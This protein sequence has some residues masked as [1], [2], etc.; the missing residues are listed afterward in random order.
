LGVIAVI[1]VGVG[2]AVSRDHGQAALDPDLVVVAPFTVLDPGLA[3]WREGMVDVLSRTLDGAG[4]LRT[5]APSVVVQRSQGRGD[6]ASAEALAHATRAGLV[7]YGSL[8]TS[9]RDSARALVTLLNAAT[10]RRL[11]E[12]DRRES[13]ERLDHL[14]DTVAVTLLSELNRIRPI[15]A[16]RVGSL[17]ARSLPALR[18]FLRGEQFFRRGAYDSAATHYDR[19]IRADS[20]FALALR[21]AGDALAWSSNPNDTLISAYSLRAGA[22]NHGLSPRDSLITLAESLSAVLH[23]TFD[24]PWMARAH[25]L[26]D[27][28]RVVT[29]RYPDDPEG[30][31]LLGEGWYHFPHAVPDDVTDGTALAAFDRAIALDSAFAP[32][33]EHPVEL[34][35]ALGGVERALAYARPFARHTANSGR[36]DLV[37]AAL[38]RPVDGLSHARL[39]AASNLSLDAAHLAFRRWPD[40]AETGLRIMR[41]LAAGRAGHFT[42]G[43]DS[44]TAA[45]LLRRA[46]TYRGRVRE[47]CSSLAGAQLHR[48]ELRTLVL[49]GELGVVPAES[50]STLFRQVLAAER[51]GVG[52]LPGGLVWWLG[53]RDRAALLR[54]RQVLSSVADS[55][56]SPGLRHVG[57]WLAA[58]AQAFTALVV[59]D[60]AAALAQLAAIAE[61]YCG[62]C[63]RT[64]HVRAEVLAAT[65]DY[66]GAL[67]L[68]RHRRSVDGGPEG[69]ET[70]LAAALEGR[71][72]ERGGRGQA[73]R[74]AY[75]FVVAA[76]S[77]GDPEVQAHV[78]GAQDAL[79]RLSP[80][81]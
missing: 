18:S 19:A 52:A 74:A 13:V 76:W 7:V 72:S 61:R 46:L 27:V 29:T 64:T 60:T 24:A 44:L 63:N 69:A 12:A 56:S 20:T 30:W 50:V 5:V 11:A 51:P 14:A 35:L 48:D 23:V 34:A 55:A 57:G 47:A 21:R 37:L 73:A 4:P 77:R 22:L 15:G 53:Q 42:L 78:R 33:Y 1:G 71:I 54:A 81:P 28:L 16:Y 62:F 3:V 79:R 65:G 58:E 66:P 68:L 43:Y 32:A 75:E 38:E 9:G 17:G 31:Y 67:Q 10:G 6:R 36:G 2:L 26:F 40:S 45:G 59:G 49:C 80:E 25:R 70:V 39:A 41:L 8:V